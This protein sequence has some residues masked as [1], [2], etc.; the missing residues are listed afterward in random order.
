MLTGKGAGPLPR[1]QYKEKNDSYIE[2]CVGG[3]AGDSLKQ[4][5]LSGYVPA[6]HFSKVKTIIYLFCIVS[7]S[8]SLKSREKIKDDK[9][10]SIYHF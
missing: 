1:P 7:D 6:L 9:L 8:N 10:T 5:S 4:F 2:L 3:V